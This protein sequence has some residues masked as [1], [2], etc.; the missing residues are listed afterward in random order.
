MKDIIELTFYKSSGQYLEAYLHRLA[1]AGY[2]LYRA[3]DYDSLKL[4]DKEIEKK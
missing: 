1:R 4:F 2:I 3:K